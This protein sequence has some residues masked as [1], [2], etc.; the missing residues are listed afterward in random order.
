MSI[1]PATAA[2]YAFID[3]L[4][5]MH[6]KALGFMPRAQLQ[7][8]IAAGHVLVAED[9]VGLPIGYCISQDRYFKRDDVGIIYQMNVSPG[10]QRALVGAALLKAVFERAA[11]GCK[12]FCCWCAQDLD[13]N[14]FWESLGFIP[15]AFRGGSSRKKRVHIFWQRRIREGDATT[16]FWY[17]CKTDSGYIRE[18]RLVFPIP[19]GTHW[20]D[21]QAVEVPEERSSALGVR[22]SAKALPRPSS[23]AP[24]AKRRGPKPGQVGIIVGGR[25]KYVNRPGSV[26]PALPALPALA[27]PKRDK[28]KR[29]A[30]KA[31]PERSR[32]IDR[33]FIKAARELRDRYLE[34][35]NSGSIL[36]NAKYAV[37]KQ[38]P[39]ANRQAQIA[40]R[41]S[42]PQAA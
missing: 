11:Y 35:F 2:D 9:E 10:K 31:C 22:S 26:A 36:P 37:A 21:V 40:N 24:K 25:I 13:A 42:L 17:P 6:S 33:E 18:D 20:K 4:Q 23:R 28:P 34:Q 38:L 15:L 8:K 7:G 30:G 16:P 1:R 27:A 29:A 39:I 12:L 3:R 5:D 19:P 41:K 14:Y 32:R